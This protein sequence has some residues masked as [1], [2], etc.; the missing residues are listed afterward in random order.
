MNP[1]NNF[2]SIQHERLRGTG[3]TC[4]STYSL[5]LELIAGRRVLHGVGF[6]AAKEYS[7]TNFRKTFLSCPAE[8]W[9]CRGIGRSGKIEEE[10][11]D[12]PRILSC[13]ILSR[14]ALSDL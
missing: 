14:G 1:G 4:T 8:C 5:S 2:A 3:R 9:G 12:T 6:D 11:G 10:T 13:S 7:R